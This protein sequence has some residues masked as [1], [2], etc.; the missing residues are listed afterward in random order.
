MSKALAIFTLS[1]KLPLT[2]LLSRKLIAS[3][4][5]H[6][7]S[8]MFLPFMKPH[9]SLEIRKG[10]IVSIL[11]AMI[12]EIILNL[13][14]AKTIMQKLFMEFVFLLLVIRMMVLEL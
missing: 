14:F 1:D 13:K 10:I 4:T 7:N 2:C 6:M 9:C 8:L 11:S 12:L 3:E 5:R